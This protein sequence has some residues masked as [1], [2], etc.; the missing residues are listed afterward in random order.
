M[1]PSPD[2]PEILA[3]LLAAEEHPHLKQEAGWLE[4]RQQLEAS[5]ELQDAFQ[6]ARIF[7]QKYPALIKFSPMPSDARARIRRALREAAPAPSPWSYRQQFAWA[8]VL[9]LFLAGLSVLSS[10]LIKQQSPYAHPDRLTADA[11][12]PAGLPPFHAFVRNNLDTPH[13]EHRAEDTVQLVNWLAEHDGF[14]PPLPESLQQARGMGCAVLESPHGNISLLCIDINGQMLKLY[15]G[16]AKQLR[17]PSTP[18][19]P[20][21]I[22]HHQALEWSNGDNVFLLI[23]GKPE[24]PMPEILL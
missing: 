21:E 1:K 20:V 22:N 4:A 5:P 19:T 16:C 24:T 17:T 12:A 7:A 13:L 11:P 6:D 3:W 18:V 8:A 23:Q 14:A 15:I 9:A 10:T 2:I